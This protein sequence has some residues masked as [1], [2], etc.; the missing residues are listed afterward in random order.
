[1][2]RRSSPPLRDPIQVVIDRQMRS[3]AST[4]GDPPPQKHC[5]QHGALETEILEAVDE[6][7][8]YGYYFGCGHYDTFSMMR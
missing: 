1:M 8:S 6:K 2:P 4:W 5:H 7:Q 3:I